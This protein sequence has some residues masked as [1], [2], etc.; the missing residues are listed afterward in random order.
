MVASSVGVLTPF[1]AGFSMTSDMGVSLGI[2]FL[3]R[4]PPRPARPAVPATRAP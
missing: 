4:I 1:S 2:W 3:A